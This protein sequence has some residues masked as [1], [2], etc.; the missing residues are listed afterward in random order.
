MSD[1]RIVFT[2]VG[3]N[4]ANAAVGE[5][6]LFNGAKAI[7]A[8]HVFSGG[9]P[10]KVPIPDGSY[11]VRLDIRGIVSAKDVSIDKDA[12]GEDE[13]SLKPFYGIQ[14]IPAEVKVNSDSWNMREEWGSIRARLNP[15]KKEMPEAYQGN[16]LHGKEHNVEYTHGCICEKTEQILQFL[17]NLDANKN[18]HIQ[19]VVRSSKAK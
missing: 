18:S 16:Y 9:I 2:K 7:L 17:W 1:Y 12:D 3:A 10:G 19:V 11:T 6:V 14:K 8:S 4:K 5:L 13:A 15:P